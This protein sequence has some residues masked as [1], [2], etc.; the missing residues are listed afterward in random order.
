MQVVVSHYLVALSS[1]S[2]RLSPLSCPDCWRLFNLANDA[3]GSGTRHLPLPPPI[4]ER[5]QVRQS[6]SVLLLEELRVW[7]GDHLLLVPPK[8]ALGKAMRHLDKQWNKLTVYTRDGRLRIDNNLTENAIRPYI[9]R[10]KAWIFSS[11]VAGTNASANLYGLVETAVA[12]GLEPYAYLK[13]VLTEL[14]CLQRKCWKILSGYC[15]ST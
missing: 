13:L 1:N 12:N 14:P 7:L 15:R 11:S 5:L 2:S 8:S 3:T 10:R 4:D 9:I 6:R